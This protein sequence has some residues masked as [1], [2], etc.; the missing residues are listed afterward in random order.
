MGQVKEL[1]EKDG[2][3]ATFKSL[4]TFSHDLFM[5]ALHYKELFKKNGL[6]IKFKSLA[7]FPHVLS[8]VMC[9]HC[10]S[11]SSL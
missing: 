6:K 3:T 9:L 8:M 5:F 7:T 10:I 4:A 1:P 2:L 11:K